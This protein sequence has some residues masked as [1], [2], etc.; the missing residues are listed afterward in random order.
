MMS[1]MVKSLPEVDQAFFKDVEQRKAI[2]D[3]TIEAFRNGIA[4]PSDEMKLLFKPWGF[5]LEKIK[6]P[7]QIWHRSLDSQSPISHAKVYE[8]TIPGAKLNLIENEGHHSLLRNNI[9]SIL[10]SIV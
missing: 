4:G 6:Y 9:K 2:I 10:K 8:N 5:E 7:I 3:S 1:Q